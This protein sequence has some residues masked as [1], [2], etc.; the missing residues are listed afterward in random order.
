MWPSSPSQR[1]AVAVGVEL[2]SRVTTVA[3]GFSVPP[4][5][6]LRSRSLVG[7]DS[8]RD[9][10]SESFWASCRVCF[11]SAPPRQVISG[12]ENKLGRWGG[13]G[14]G[15]LHRG[16]TWIKRPATVLIRS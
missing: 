7:L 4:L 1:S 16:G 12:K 8:R 5:G 15:R 9:P 13:I 14:G 3:M 10:W 2:A 6:W 11:Q